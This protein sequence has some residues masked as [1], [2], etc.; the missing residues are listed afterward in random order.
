ALVLEPA[1]SAFDVELPSGDMAKTSACACKRDR[2]D[3][4]KHPAASM[5]NGAKSTAEVAV[6]G[7]GPAGL[8]TA[9]ALAAG[10]V[11]TVLISPP[12]HPDHRT[13]AL[14]L[15]SVTALETLDIWTQ[16]R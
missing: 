16:C 12:A 1:A 9:I 15:G 2:Y 4:W 8:T 3:K 5:A 6:V 13:T 7:G 11:E 14:L 10:G